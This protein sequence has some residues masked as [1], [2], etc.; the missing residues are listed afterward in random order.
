MLLREWPDHRGAKHQKA[1]EA[2]LEVL[3]GNVQPSVA[4]NAFIA[5]AEE[6]GIL[7]DAQ[8]FPID[9]DFIRRESDVSIPLAAE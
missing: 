1:L 8:A 6:S 3:K 5:A 2:V 4:R 7:V 9:V